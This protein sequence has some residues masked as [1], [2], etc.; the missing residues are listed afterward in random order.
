MTY[1]G[2]PLYLF[3]PGPE[4]FFGANFFESAL[5][6]PPWRTA[7]YL[8]SPT[9]QAAPGPANLETEA[10]QTGTTYTSTVLAAEMLPNAV[11][12]GA[13]ITVYS[14]SRDSR[15]QSSCF[16][17]CA[18][19]FI[20]VITSGWP[21]AQPGVSSR[22]VG[23]ITR[24]GG[25]LQVTY[26]GHPLYIYSQEEPLVGSAGLVTTGFAGNGDGIHAFGGTFS[27]VSP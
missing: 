2:H 18:K 8:I 9:G 5:P 12:G 25:S 1:A 14:F 27:V 26:A 11:P 15:W 4:S 23:V 22:R 6:L 13:A 20:P 21:T 24:P 10:P 17:Q 3:D 16:G 19:D 7:W